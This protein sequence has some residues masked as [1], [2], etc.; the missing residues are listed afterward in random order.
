LTQVWQLIR[1]SLFACAKSLDNSQNNDL[2]TPLQVLRDALALSSTV[3]PCCV[4]TIAIARLGV[5]GVVVF[6]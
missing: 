2:V 3:R 5:L 1:T 4:V 6:T